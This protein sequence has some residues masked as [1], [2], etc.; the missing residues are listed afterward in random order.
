MNC[1]LPRLQNS[2]NLQSRTGHRAETTQRLMRS[3]ERLVRV[4]R[5]SRP[6]SLPTGSAPQSPRAIA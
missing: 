3:S 2:N 1:K 5:T 4:A 6:G